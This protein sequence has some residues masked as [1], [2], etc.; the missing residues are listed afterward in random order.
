MKSG[1]FYD[2]HSEYQRRV[3]EAGDD[4]IGRSIEA[5]DIDPEA[6]ALTIAD[7]GAGTGVT[8]V[9]AA[10][11][12]VAALRRRHEELPVLVVHNDLMTND[13]SQLFGN[14]AAPGGYLPLPGGPIYVAAA[15]GSFFTQVVP[16]ATVHLGM[17]SNAAHWFC[18]QPRLETPG[19]MYFLVDET[20]HG[21]GEVHVHVSG[22]GVGCGLITTGEAKRSDRRAGLSGL[23]AAP[24]PG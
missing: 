1:G 6:P 4:L 11:A 22:D 23:H 10:R 12:A 19:G 18:E 20:S 5:L 2:L 24:A 8:S 21:G 14:I 16:T 17:C 13:F 15:G 9:H 3:I 7:Y